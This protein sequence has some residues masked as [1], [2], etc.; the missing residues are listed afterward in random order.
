M[1][2]IFVGGEIGSREAHLTR[3][4]DW[5]L[6]QDDASA[7]TESK[8]TKKYFTSTENLILNPT[9]APYILI[10]HLIFFNLFFV[11]DFKLAR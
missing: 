8:T 10:L 9:D 1:V 2:T 6:E 3:A 7:T 5:Y 11:W 4:F